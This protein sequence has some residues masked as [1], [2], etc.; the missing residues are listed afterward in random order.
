AVS[1]CTGDTGPEGPAGSAGSSG[2]AGPASL[3]RLDDAGDN[4]P[5]NGVA[6]NAGVDDNGNGTLDDA[7]IDSTEY[8]CG[9]STEACT[10]FDGDLYIADALDLASFKLL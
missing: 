10:T 1:A 8:V 4:C 2:D 5:G 6:I 9:S 3:I 7:E